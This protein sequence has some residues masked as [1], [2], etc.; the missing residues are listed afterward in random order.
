MSSRCV[1]NEPNHNIAVQTRRILSQPAS[2]HDQYRT[3]HTSHN[4]QWHDFQGCQLGS[5]ASGRSSKAASKSVLSVAG[6]PELA[7]SQFCQCRSSKLVRSVGGRSSKAS[8]KSVLPV[9]GVPE[10]AVSRTGSKSVLS[11]QVFQVSQFC[12]WQEFQS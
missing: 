8:S 10:L 7:V 3:R 12:Q 6:V 5:S 1:D 4:Y 11:V 9:A 2:A